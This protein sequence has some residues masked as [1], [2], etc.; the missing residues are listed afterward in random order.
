MVLSVVLYIFLIFYNDVGVVCCKEIAL[1]STRWQKSKEYVSIIVIT[2]TF[3]WNCC[4]SLGKFCW[5]VQVIGSRGGGL[6]KLHWVFLNLL[7]CLYQMLLVAWICRIREIGFLMNSE[8]ICI[9]IQM[10]RM[11]LLPIF[12]QAFQMSGNWGR[13][14]RWAHHPRLDNGDHQFCQRPLVPILITIYLSFEPPC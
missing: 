5:Y 14:P 2:L 7:E 3:E 13:V 9:L 11:L 1:F 6:H 10:K 8:G 4:N 12:L